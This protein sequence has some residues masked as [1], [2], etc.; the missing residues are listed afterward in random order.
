M[1]YDTYNT[2]NNQYDTYNKMLT[3]GKQTGTYWTLQWKG[4]LAMVPKLSEGCAFEESHPLTVQWPK[5]QQAPS[6]CHILT[7]PNC[8]R[9]I[10]CV[11]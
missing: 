1:S 3:K 4:S 7:S 9:S 11:A 2:Y 6:N 5:C 8:G 10:C